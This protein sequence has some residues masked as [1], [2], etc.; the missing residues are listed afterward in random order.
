M[1]D[2]DYTHIEHSMLGEKLGLKDWFGKD[3][4]EFVVVQRTADGIVDN[5]NWKLYHWDK[6]MP[7]ECILIFERDLQR[8]LLGDKIS[9]M[10]RGEISDFDKEIKD[11]HCRIIKLIVETVKGEH[12]YYERKKTEYLSKKRDAAILENKTRTLMG[13]PELPVIDP[14]EKKILHELRYW[15]NKY[16]ESP[17]SKPSHHLSSGFGC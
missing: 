14:D 11:A 12:E 10:I 9:R 5:I 2:Y 16:H 4:Y 1:T 3:A 17:L 6:E 8:W 7:D 15:K 13:L